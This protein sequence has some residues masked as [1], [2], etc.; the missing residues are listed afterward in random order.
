M[1]STYMYSVLFI[2]FELIYIIKFYFLINDLI[3][4]GIL[5]IH[6]IYII[7]FSLILGNFIVSLIYEITCYETFIILICYLCLDKIICKLFYLHFLIMLLCNLYIYIFFPFIS[8]YQTESRR[9]IKT[10]YREEIIIPVIYLIKLI[11]NKKS[12]ME[13]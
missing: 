13:E 6:S 3:Q 9:F 11:F 5:K 8:S 4:L 12:T 7:I 2:F 10:L 1:Y